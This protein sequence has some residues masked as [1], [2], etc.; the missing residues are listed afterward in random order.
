[1]FDGLCSPEQSMEEVSEYLPETSTPTFTSSSTFNP[2]GPAVGTQKH[3]YSCNYR[4]SN[5]KGHLHVATKAVCFRCT[6]LFGWETVRIII[7][8]CT[9]IA[10]D[11]SDHGTISIKTK[12]NV[13]HEMDLF[14]MDIATV[15][16]SLVSAWKDCEKNENKEDR[17][18]DSVRHL[19]RSVCL[20][21]EFP[22]SHCED[23]DTEEEEGS[24][25]DSINLSVGRADRNL[26]CLPDDLEAKMWSE[27]RNSKDEKFTENVA[28]VSLVL[29][30]G[31]N[32]GLVPQFV[33][34]FAI[35]IP[36]SCTFFT[37]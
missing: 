27:L 24:D 19:Y 37:P 26:P 13:L 9:I 25:E 14:D 4:K 30:T 17:N 33:L 22:D 12:N 15:R 3:V 21:S 16:N 2:F 29:K 1:M 11:Q 31:V 8:L 32:R 28:V 35:T 34:C 20:L 7:P 6:I 18:T 10:I 36:F 23:S 5:Q